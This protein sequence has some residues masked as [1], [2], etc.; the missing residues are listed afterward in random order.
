MSESC[1]RSSGRSRAITGI[2]SSPRR[3]DVTCHPFIA[4][5][6]E[7]ATSEFVT[8][9]RLA[10]SGSTRS[11]TWKPGSSQSSRTRNAFGAAR[12]ISST[13]L[14]IDRNTLMSF[15][16]SSGLT[17]AMPVTRNSAGYST[18]FVCNCRTSAR[19]PE[20]RQRRKTG[21]SLACT[22]PESHR[23]SQGSS[24]GSTVATREKHILRTLSGSFYG[25]DT[26]IEERLRASES[27]SMR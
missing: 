24:K 1:A 6:E 27:E 10:R 7:D 9:A 16:S 17:S 5:V 21:L 23:C 2:C 12:R 18:G 11:V 15:C 22:V 20:Q 8:P 13:W 14:V 26:N 19:T 25:A 4:E 3:R